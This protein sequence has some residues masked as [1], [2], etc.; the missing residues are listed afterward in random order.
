MQK[1]I[2]SLPTLKDRRDNAKIFPLEISYRGALSGFLESCKIP[3]KD[4]VA[5]S[6][7]TG[8]GL[9]DYLVFSNTRR[10]IK[11]IIATD[12]VDNPV[13]KEGIKILKELGDW[14]FKKVKAEKNLPFIDGYFD[15]AY[16]LDVIEHVKK[17]HLFLSEQYRVLKKGG[18]LIIGTPN[19]F[20]PANII[21]LLLGKLSFPVKIGSNKEIGDYIHIQEFSDFQLR[22]LLEEVGFKD[23]EIKHCYF[24]IWPLRITFNLYPKGNIGKGMCHYLMVRCRK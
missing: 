9:S 12:I 15:L 17:P 22:N 7:S 1:K 23:I 13:D 20:R 6:V 14:K 24:G 16:H 21:K 4:S 8:D 10:K 2:D 18:T 3:N 11:K 5:L 19:I